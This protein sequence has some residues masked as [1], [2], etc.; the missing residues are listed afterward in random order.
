MK[1]LDFAWVLMTY[2]KVSGILSKFAGACVCIFLDQM[3]PQFMQSFIESCCLDVLLIRC[4]EL[5][6]FTLVLVNSWHL[7]LQVL[8]GQAVLINLILMLRTVHMRGVINIADEEM[9]RRYNCKYPCLCC[10]LHIS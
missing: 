8:H 5:V 2:S 7:S 4:D 1:N 6:H 10:L 3:M 9:S